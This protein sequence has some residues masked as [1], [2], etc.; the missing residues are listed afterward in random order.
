MPCGTH[1]RKNMNY[2]K[3][4]RNRS[5]RLKILGL[6]NWVPD[7][8]MVRLQYL[9][10]TGRKL[11]LKSPRR[12][13][14]KVQHYKLYYRNPVMSKCVDKYEVRNY[15]SDK[16]YDKY[17]NELYGVYDSIYD[18]DFRLLPKQFVVKTT[19][20]GGNNEVYICRDNNDSSQ[21]EI[22]NRFKDFVQRK[23]KSPGREYAYYG[24]KRPH[25]IVEKLLIDQE[26]PES[27]I[28]DY[29]FFCFNGKVF[30]CQVITNRS[31]DEHIDF[32][33]TEWHR[34]IGLVGLNVKASNSNK[35]LTVPKNYNE[36][37][38][39]ASK[40]SEGFPFVRVDLYN[41]NS[42]IIFGEFTFYPASGYGSF[43]PDN[44]DFELGDK[45]NI[46]Y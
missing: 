27:S 10:Y 24:I 7:S 14:E 30:V 1:K 35:E 19:D 40:L 12:F 18:I 29:K 16:G 32:F 21:A 26:A 46:T 11:N 43:I 42:H 34:L 13:T 23:K 37:V 45:F 33:D 2:K 28:C 41:I 3:I 22:I 25:I 5:I 9:I 17:L 38:H 8:I 31:E 39:V 6:L 4:I 36:M 15:L 44:F 20:G